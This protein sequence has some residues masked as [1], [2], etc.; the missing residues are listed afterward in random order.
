M[1]VLHLGFVCLLSTVVVSYSKEEPSPA[2]TS[3]HAKSDSVNEAQPPIEDAC[4]LLT[5]DDLK[6]VLGAEPKET[7]PDRTS[8][9]GFVIAQCYFTM[10]DSAE[11][12]NLRVVQR[13]TGADA[14]DPRKVW[15]ETFARDLKR[16]IKERKKGPPVKVEKLGDEA[17]WMG[18]AKY[19]GL[20]VLKGNRHFRLGV[21]GEPN[22][23]KKIEKASKLARAILKRL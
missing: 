5:H 7:K 15:E 3:S 14:R 1:R 22:Q 4:T 8:E 2:A 6:A 23:E 20:Y 19:G 11:S 18:G 12:V 17:Y 21:G 16:A 9:Q 10:P 13:G